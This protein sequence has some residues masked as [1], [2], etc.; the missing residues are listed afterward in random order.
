[1]TYENSKLSQYVHSI[2]KV[3]MV[4]GIGYFVITEYVMYWYLADHYKTTI[5]VVTG[6]EDFENGGYTYRYDYEVNDIK[7]SVSALPNNSNNPPVIGDKYLVK[8]LPFFPSVS[9]PKF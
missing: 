6:K 1:M 8:Y 2:L 5:G 7:Y 3:L 9:V 4:L